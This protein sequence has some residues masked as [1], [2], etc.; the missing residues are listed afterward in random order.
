MAANGCD[1]TVP[2]FCCLKNVRNEV[3]ND[4]RF[5]PGAVP[6]S[7]LMI[8]VG[9][10]DGKQNPKEQYYGRKTAGAIQEINKTCQASKIPP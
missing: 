5:Q 1:D 8:I 7:Y 3:R 6:T 10:R 4:L 9:N 2:R